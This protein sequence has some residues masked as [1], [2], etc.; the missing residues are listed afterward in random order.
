MVNWILGAFGAFVVVAG[1]GALLV[2]L[3]VPEDQ[4]DR[5]KVAF[6]VLKLV[7]GAGIGSLT[8]ALARLAEIAPF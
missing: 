2:V 3:S 1:I 8:V 6:G 5:R 4:P 7:F